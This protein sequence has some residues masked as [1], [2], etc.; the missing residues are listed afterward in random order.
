MK[1]KK[2]IIPLSDSQTLRFIDEF[3][4]VNTDFLAKK[5]KNKIKLEKQK[6]STE[7][8]RNN[9]KEL[10]KQLYNTQFQKDYMCLI[11]DKKSH[12]D[13]ANKGFY[14]NGIKYKRFLGTNGGIKNSTIIYVSERIYPFFN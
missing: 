7:E 5:I 6:K 9:I 12:Y 10:Y 4:N 14:I 11:I 3:N 1:H 13:R 2:D 8:T